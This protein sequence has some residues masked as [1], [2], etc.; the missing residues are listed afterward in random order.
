[1]KE[2]DRNLRKIL[3][4]ARIGHLKD[5]ALDVVRKSARLEGA[6]AP[7]TA[8]GLGHELRLLNS[9]HSNLIEGHKT[10]ISD[11][12][13][14]LRKEWALDDQKR[15]AQELCSA[16]A[17]VEEEMMHR[18][19]RLEGQVTTLEFIQWLHRHFYTQL[20]EAHRFTHHG[21]GFTNV[22][23]N[24]GSW[25]ELEV[26]VR[27]GEQ[28]GPDGREVPHLMEVF[29]NLY[30]PRAFHG[31]ERMLVIAGGHHRLAWLHPFWDGNGRV[32]R[33]FTG[34]CLASIDVNVH[35]I[36]S[37]SRGLSRN[38]NEY[39]VYLWAGDSFEDEHYADFI[40]W[41][42]EQCLDQITFME[43]LL[44]MER[45]ERRIEDYVNLLIRLGEEGIRRESAILLREA[46]RSGTVQRGRAP[47]LLHVSERHSR[48]MVSPLIERGLLVSES[49]KKPLRFGFPEHAMP[50]YFPKLFDPDIMGDISS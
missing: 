34:A 33:L 10:F 18:V 21:A 5:M 20:S 38:K 25:R 39:M 15:Y 46:F 50:E 36:W 31:D 41:F 16:H 28:L 13:R 43:K 23:V 42:L 26:S 2:D 44:D 48:R 35:G 3:P 22:P 49:Q 4:K 7:E 19:A 30:D 9:Y 6:L 8:V 45:I 37:L 29:V 24:P 14:A 17:V 40:E 12:K 47:A 11:I 1:M 27:H 32:I